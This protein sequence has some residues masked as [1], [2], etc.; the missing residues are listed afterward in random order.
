MAQRRKLLFFKSNC[1]EK[2]ELKTKVFTAA[3]SEQHKL[4]GE[5]FFLSFKML[6]AGQDSMVTETLCMS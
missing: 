1:L 4:L 2:K 3:L 6:H 5:Q